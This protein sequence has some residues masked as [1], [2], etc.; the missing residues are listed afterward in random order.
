MRTLKMGKRYKNR[1]RENKRRENRREKTGERKQEREKREKRK[2]ERETWRRENS[3]RSYKRSADGCDVKKVYLS[4][5]IPI[6]DTWRFY[7][8]CYRCSL[9]FNVQ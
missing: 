8:T 6:W 1:R 2:Q 9:V 5:T 7:E 4:T 3:G